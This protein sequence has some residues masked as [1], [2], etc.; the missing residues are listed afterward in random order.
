M[1]SKKQEELKKDCNSCGSSHMDTSQG[2]FRAPCAAILLSLVIIG[3]L[4]RLVQLPDGFL[5]QALNMILFV[6]LMAIFWVTFQRFF[7]NQTG[8]KEC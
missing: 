8:D 3:V 2:D 5:G 1:E 6:V 7:D 4:N